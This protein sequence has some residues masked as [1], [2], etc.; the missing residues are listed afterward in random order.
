MITTPF[1]SPHHFILPASYHL[2][3]LFLSKLWLG[4]P[5]ESSCPLSPNCSASP[6]SWWHSSEWSPFFP[7]SLLS[8][9]PYFCS[10]EL[11][12]WK[13][14]KR[15]HHHLERDE[16]LRDIQIFCI[17][18]ASLALPIKG[19]ETA[20]SGRNMGC[21]PATMVSGWCPFPRNGFLKALRCL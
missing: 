14:E 11:H 19:R 13:K 20:S 1:L 18:Q 4:P 7:S 10:W 8:S 16:L 2:L 12:P 15:K 17:H 5:W 3:Q 6:T 21:V 9:W